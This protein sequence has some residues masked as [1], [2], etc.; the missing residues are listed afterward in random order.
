MIRMIQSISAQQAKKYFTEAL[1]Q[2]DYYVNTQELPGHI[3]GKLAVRLGIEGLA[4]KSIFQ[5]LAE[6]LHPQTGQKLTPRNSERR[7]VGY[8]INFHCPKSVSILHALSKD[9]HILEAF[10]HSVTEIMSD[11]EHDSK[12]RKRKAGHDEDMST[13]ELVWADFIHQTARPVDGAAPDPHLHSHCFTF[14]MTWD[15]S[16]KR[17]KAAQFRDIKRD[18]PYYQAKFHKVLSDRLSTLGYA[19]RKTEAAFEVEGV[20]QTVIDRFSKR[21][22]EIGQAAKASGVT[23]AKEL[24]KLGGRTRARKQKGM[25]MDDL[26]KDWRRQIRSLGLSQAQSRKLIR[27]PV[28]QAPGTNQATKCLEHAIKHCFERASVVQDRRLLAKAFQFAV[29]NP[30]TTPAAI[31]AMFDGHAGLYK[32]QEGSKTLCTSWDIIR[33]EREMIHLAQADGSGSK[34]FYDTLPAIVLEG[35]QRSAV[36]GLLSRKDR[37]MI[38]EG[39]AGTG[40]TTLMKTAIGLIEQSGKTVFV[41]APSSEASRGVLREEGFAAAETVAKL[42][43]DP[44]LQAGLTDQVLWV[45]EAG[46][47]GVK[48]MTALLSLASRLRARLILSG[49]TRQHSSVARGDALRVLK[50]IGGVWTTSLTDIRRQKHVG[51]RK[52]VQAISKGHVAE[53]FDVL[54]TL[55]SIKPVEAGGQ[56]KAMA[57]AYVQTV[58]A[59][60]SALIVSPTHKQGLEVTQAVREALKHSNKIGKTDHKVVQL[61]PFN[62]TEAEKSDP[63]NYNKGQVIKMNQNKP[64]MPRGSTWFVDDIQDS[65][66][67]LKNEK[68]KETDFNVETEKD[69]EVYQQSDISLAKG[70]DIRITRNGFDENK[71][72]LNNGQALKIKSINKKGTIIAVNPISKKMYELP[73]SFGH[74]DHGYCLTSHAS[75]GKTVDEVFIYQPASTF[76]ATDLKQFYVSVSRGRDKVHLYTDDKEALIGHAS[77]MRSRQSGLELL[78]LKEAFKDIAPRRHTSSLTRQSRPLHSLSF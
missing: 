7:T 4:T 66:L 61:I 2:S 13:G 17:H 16:E 45:D 71:Q 29:G 70:D 21:T 78:G 36:A 59:G 65:I 40:K 6:N 32:G 10:Q 54:D 47:L 38:L 56:A 76:P 37:V 72:R 1:G 31:Q 55:G 8:D 26:K 39:R 35:E 77:N 58:K 48:D 11:I 18:M 52:A 30:A 68:G 49:D 5:S 15:D 12:T 3:R 43:A 44:Q 51:Y 46:L 42:L 28:D 50:D 23:D 67:R 14:N 34:P 60:K 62:M 24:D 75:Q 64:G 27:N 69:F 74:I 41:A 63:R 73:R 20:P 33:E 22:D 19:I 9:N 53:G 25:T 57:A